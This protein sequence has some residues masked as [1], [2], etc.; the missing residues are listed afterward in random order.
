MGAVVLSVGRLLPTRTGAALVLFIEIGAGLASYIGFGALLMPSLARPIA[1][2]WL[3]Q[4]RTLR[5]K[6]A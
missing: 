2:R 5:R 1:N 4:L 3:G 6:W